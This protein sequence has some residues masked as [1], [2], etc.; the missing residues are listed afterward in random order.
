M[1]LTQTTGELFAK[2]NALAPD[3]DRNA[4]T[5]ADRTYWL[6]ELTPRATGRV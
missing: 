1:K 6:G 3:D 5:N 4:R 2:Y